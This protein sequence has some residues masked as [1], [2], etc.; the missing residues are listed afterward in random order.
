MQSNVA[1]TF[2]I[3]VTAFD[4][5]VTASW[6]F[7]VIILNNIPTFDVPLI[8]QKTILFKAS[9]LLDD[10][11]SINHT[12]NGWNR[13]NIQPIDCHEINASHETVL[14]EESS[15]KILAYLWPYLD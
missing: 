1:G 9:T 10:Y 14:N 7:N 8:D 2:P 3:T 5:A 6:L 12:S 15:K 13:Y 11:I 4:G